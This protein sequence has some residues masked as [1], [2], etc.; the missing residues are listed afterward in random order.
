[1][2]ANSC[3]LT[4]AVLFDFGGTLD[5]DGLPWK[6]RVARLFR[7]EGLVVTVERFD[8]LFYA[9][10]D[11]LVGAV[12]P[13]LPLRET[14]FRLVA[15]LARSL[16]LRDD[17]MVDRVTTRFVEHA[18]ENLRGNRPLLWELSRRYRLGLV[19]N[20]YGNLAAVCAECGIRE[21]FGVILDSA[22]VGCA[23]P[24]PKIF[25]IAAEALGLAPAHALFVGDSRPRD[26]AGAR[27]A[28]MPHVWLVGETSSDGQPCCPGDA[29]I[30]SLKDLEELLL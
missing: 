24:D 5:A 23:K 26:M 12:P 2:S 8:P 17:T 1:M 20:F 4:G 13:T 21:L 16:G 30:R 25:R 7:Q 27:A 29:V 9:A 22:D 15:G 18:V 3:G 6:E 28:G 10:D 11:A 14:V 19:A